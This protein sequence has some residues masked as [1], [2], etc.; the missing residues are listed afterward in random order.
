MLSSDP[1]AW[2]YP[3]YARLEVDTKFGLFSPAHQFD[4]LASSVEM[5]SPTK[6]AAMREWSPDAQMAMLKWLSDV[7]Q[8][9]QTQRRRLNSGEA[10][11]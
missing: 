6:G 9:H 2:L 1:H 8:E 5:E 3:I 11:V 4:A 10:E 7:V